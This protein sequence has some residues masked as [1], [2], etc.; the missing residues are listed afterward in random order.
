MYQKVKSVTKKGEEY[1]TPV[2]TTTRVE[3]GD[4]VANIKGLF[5]GNSELSN[6]IYLI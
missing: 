5:D 4:A 6:T 2:N 1:V 3:I